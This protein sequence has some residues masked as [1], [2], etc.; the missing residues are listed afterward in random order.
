MLPLVEVTYLVP[1]GRIGAW[2]QEMNAGPGEHG[3]FLGFKRQP[4]GLVHASLGLVPLRTFFRP[5]E[6]S[7]PVPDLVV[8]R[9]ENGKT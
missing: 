5:P 6:P 4:S 1:Q 2:F 9:N 3:D 7:D 8:I